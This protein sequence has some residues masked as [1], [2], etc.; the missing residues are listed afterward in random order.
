MTFSL[1][2]HV[3]F[4]I[5]IVKIL[6]KWKF[7]VL[8]QDIFV[9]I[10]YRGNEEVFLRLIPKLNRLLE[11]YRESKDTNTFYE[12]YLEVYPWIEQASKEVSGYISDVAKFEA[13]LMIKIE[14][15][16]RE[17]DTS[18]NTSFKTFVIS[19]IN[20]EKGYVI[21]RNKHKPRCVSLEALD[22]KLAEF[23]G[24]KIKCERPSVDSYA[25]A[26][27]LI[28]LLAQ[29]DVRNREILRRWSDGE[30]DTYI[31]EVLAHL[32]GGKQ[33]SHYRYINR[34]RTK[35]RERYEGVLIS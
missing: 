35:L 11:K 22:E 18:K 30:D 34:F 7:I 25:I 8:K 9:G 5:I 24:L 15:A 13:R 3:E 6:L 28:T 10:I 23:G 33:S 16:I 12:I 20:R 26:K 17:F 1:P 4:I 31:S 27:D 2:K 19:I 32:L 21:K 29:G 14:R